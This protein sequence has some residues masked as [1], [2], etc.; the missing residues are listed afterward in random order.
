MTL[1]TPSQDHTCRDLPGPSG[2]AH[3][4]HGGLCVCVHAWGQRA[5]GH[6]VFGG[7]ALGG[8]CVGRATRSRP[9]APPRTPEEPVLTSLCLV[10]LTPVQSSLAATATLFSTHA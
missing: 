10:A 5:L 6:L 8:L 4:P 7:G 9:P 1:A 2:A 3:H